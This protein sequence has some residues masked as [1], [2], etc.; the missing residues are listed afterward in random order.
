MRRGNS[1]ELGS[2]SQF[3]GLK[4]GVMR[5]AFGPAPTTSGNAAAHL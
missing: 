1:H 2:G 3:F 4:T 5:I